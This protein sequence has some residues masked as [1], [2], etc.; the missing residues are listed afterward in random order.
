MYASFPFS[1]NSNVKAYYPTEIS[2]EYVKVE[3]LTTAVPG[4]TPVIMEC[5]S[6]VTS[7]N[8][9]DLL[10]STSASAPGNKLGG[11]YYCNDV[12]ETTKHRNVVDYKPATMRVLGRAADGRLAFVTSPD[13]KYIPAN[14]AYLT[15]PAGT[16]ETL[17]VVKEIPSGIEQVQSDVK[18]VRKGVFTLSGQRVAD[19]TDGLSHGV[20]IVDGQ[21]V[22]VN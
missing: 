14:K 7:Q 17:Y 1:L 13:L 15:V 12:K 20:Y 3:E 18:P 4:A 22:V 8:K 19:T 10:T 2:G 21:K 5:T 6:N 9:V 11:T 16:P